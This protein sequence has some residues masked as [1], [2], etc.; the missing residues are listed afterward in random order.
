MIYKRKFHLIAWSTQL[1][2]LARVAQGCS[3]EGPGSLHMQVAMNIGRRRLHSDKRPN[4]L[5][6]AAAG[7]QLKCTHS[8]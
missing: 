7:R 4:I 1:V 8:D 5:F 2:Q 3:S 6:L